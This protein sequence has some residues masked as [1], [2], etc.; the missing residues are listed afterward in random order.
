MA[1]SAISQPP[2]GF[3]YCHLS[4]GFRIETA[5]Y[6]IESSERGLHCPAGGFHIDP[7]RPAERAVIT[8]AHADH[9]RPGSRH[10]LCSEACEPLL[11]ER[12]HPGAEIETIPYGHAVT[13]NGA[14]VS[15]HPAGHLP[16]SAQ[17]R[18]E[19]KGEIW[20]VSGDYKIEADPVCEP[21]DPVFCHTFVSECTFGLP[22]YRW[23][24]QNEVVNAINA[25]WKS[26]R[27]K[28]LNSALF[29]YALGKSQRLLAGL[30]A[31]IGPILVHGA[32]DRFVERYR[33]MGID[34]PPTIRATADAAAD[35]KG[36]A[37]V[38][39]PPSALG[40]PWLRKF[41]P[42]STAIASGWMLVRGNRR[43]RGADRGFVLSDH[44]DWPGLHQ[45][46]AATAAERVG[47]VHGYTDIMARWLAEQGMEAF[48][49]DAPPRSEGGDEDSDTEGADLDG[50]T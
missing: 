20:V 35:H 10:Y 16:G 21:F 22:I 44:A 36:R 11:R 13:L 6:M 31:S 49:L 38:I 19:H 3:V 27:E 32:V 34:L 30:D 24:P 1:E 46:F 8:H 42:C 43:R 29:G 18:I 40:T 14:R 50:G 37:M 33:E 47:L 5:A 9:A 26:N 39:A 2:P 23:K 45:A 17:V 7:W 15:L 12:V 4:I 28:G 25:W 41:Q 48:V